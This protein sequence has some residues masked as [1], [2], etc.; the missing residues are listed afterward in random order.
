MSSGQAFEIGRPDRDHLAEVRR[1]QLQVIAERI[2]EVER[3][4]SGRPESAW[5]VARDSARE[6]HTVK[7]AKPRR[8]HREGEVRMG[9]ERV[10]TTRL[11]EE[12]KFGLGIAEREGD[13]QRTV[14]R[15]HLRRAMGPMT[16]EGSAV[17]LPAEPRA[18]DAN[19][20]GFGRFEVGD[21]ERDVGQS[22]SEVGCHARVLRLAQCSN[23]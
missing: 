19:V 22:E 4:L 23:Q 6:E 12:L 11:E 14:L 3:A 15:V 2:H 16:K 9:P 7:L 13:V 18:E 20:E 8:G 17:E 21:G 10:S 1:G 5:A